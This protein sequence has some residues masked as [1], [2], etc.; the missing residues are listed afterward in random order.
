MPKQGKKI[1]KRRSTKKA[2]KKPSAISAAVDNDAVE[3]VNFTEKT[4]AQIV[5]SF[6]RQLTTPLPASYSTYRTIRRQPTV[7]LVRAMVRAA[8]LAGS[9]SVDQD[10]DIEDKYGDEIKKF[11]ADEFEPK[12]EHIVGTALD[13]GGDFGWS[14]FELV[15]DHDGEHTI[16]GKAKAL[17]QDLT[18]I[19][20]DETTGD[21]W[22]FRQ[23][24]NGT[25]ADVVDK[26]AMNIA[27]GV[28][29]SNWYGRGLLENIRGTYNQWR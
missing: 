13:G 3:G 11:I 14:P 25:I 6:G 7:S 18:T 4:R 9:W 8:I 26:Y 24:A 27:F 17:L 16:L 15:F 21:F 23:T 2:S 28:E 5:T 12:R 10:D 22:G 1:R 29:G 19:I 20:V